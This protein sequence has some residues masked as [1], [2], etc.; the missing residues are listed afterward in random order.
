MCTI[1]HRLLSITQ[2]DKAYFGQ[3]D[4]QQLA[5][6]RQMVNQLKL[7][8][9]IVEGPTIRESDGLAMS[10]RNQLLNS[11]QRQA[12]PIIFKTL[13]EAKQ[14]YG[15][16]PIKA[17]LKTITNTINSQDDMQVDYVDIVNPNNLKSI[18]SPDYNTQAHILVAVFVGA[19]R[20]IDNLALND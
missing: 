14:S 6:V 8:T 2:A 3:K 12:A 4:F 20:L 1:V 10:S 13:L 9:D 7:N 18:K 5:I 11:K 15:Q 19:V 16:R 17:I